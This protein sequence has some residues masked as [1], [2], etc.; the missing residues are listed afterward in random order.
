MNI[1]K[2]QQAIMVFFRFLD[3]PREV[4]DLVYAEVG[5]NTLMQF[6]IYMTKGPSW[7]FAISEP[8]HR[9]PFPRRRPCALL[10]TS[11]Q[12]RTEMLNYIVLHI[13][14]KIPQVSILM[15]HA[16]APETRIP[17]VLRRQLRT[18]K[19]GS[20]RVCT[21]WP[22]DPFN[23]PCSLT[24]YH[25]G[26]MFPRLQLVTIRGRQAIMSSVP[27]EL[28]QEDAT[29]HAVVVRSQV[30]KHSSAIKVLYNLFQDKPFDVSLYLTCWL[31]R[32]GD[33]EP[34]SC[35]VR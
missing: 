24:E 25:L 19:I 1:A 6:N 21:L 12:L 30:A 28:A 22:G 7:T 34:L 20:S 23:D 32:P 13:P 10:S 3:L 9:H 29:S 5:K 31:R 17:S 16:L 14:L 33:R 2:F 27:L 11:Q 35:W 15:H 26:D 8:D 4:R 18:I